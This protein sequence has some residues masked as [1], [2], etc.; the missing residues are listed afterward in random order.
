MKETKKMESKHS[1]MMEMKEM[2]KGAGLEKKE[3]WKVVGTKGKKCPT[4]GHMM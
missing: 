1:K 4:C 2:K 3:S